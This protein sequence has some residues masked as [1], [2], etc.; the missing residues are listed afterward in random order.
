MLLPKIVKFVVQ[1]VVRYYLVVLLLAGL[2]TAVCFPR[3][4]KFFANINTD[5]TKLIPEHYKSVE[6]ITE[7]REKFKSI[8]TAILV[9]EDENPQ[10]AQDL[11]ANLATFLEKD[12]IIDEVE[13]KKRGYQFFE[14]HVLLFLELEDLETIRDRIDRRIQQEKLGSLYIDFEDNGEDE[15][16][17]FGDIE[18]KYKSKYSSGSTSPYYANDQETVYAMYIYPLKDPEEITDSKKFYENLQQKVAQFFKENKYPSSKIYFT[19]TIRTHVDEYDTLIHDLKKAGLISGLGIFL[20]LSLY[21]RRVITVGLLFLPISMAILITFAFSSLFIENL[22]LVTSFLFAILGGLGVEIGIHF[23]SRY[24]EERRIGK[25]I[26]QA[27]FAVLYHTGGSALTSA[28]SVAATFLILMVND[29]KGFSEFG[30]IAG[31]G[32]IMNYLCYVLVFPSLLV[33]AEKLHLLRFKRSIGL[34]FDQTQITS[35][36][37]LEHPKRFPVPKFVLV[38]LSVFAIISIIDLP[39]LEFE[40][41]FS[42]I[43]SNIPASLEAREK[44]RLTS[45]SVNSPAIVI[46]KNKEQAQAIKQAVKKLQENPGSSVNDFKSYYDLMPD[47]QMAKLE[48]IGQMH[49]LLEDDTLKLVKG[50]HKEDIERFKDVL[51]K[52][53]PINEEDIPPK[54]KEIFQGNVKGDTA[55]IGYINPLPLLEMD[56]GRNAIRFAKEIQQI[57]TPQGTFYPSNNAIVFA[58]VLRTMMKDSKRVIIMAFGIV[59]LI[60]LLDFRSVKATCLVLSPIV[61]GVL[62]LSGFMYILKLKLNFYN[63]IAAPIVVGTS[64]DNSV[65]LYH[66]Y[67]E[68]GKGSLIYALRSTGG[69]AFMS[70]MT[71]ICGFLGLVFA[72]HNGLQSIGDLAVTGMVACLITT[73]VFFPALLQVIEDRKVKKI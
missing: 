47:D 4:S 15:E 50:E 11:M 3:A 46:L 56:D 69:A 19:G 65:H 38:C 59:F 72:F 16:F 55:Q 41:R 51:A 34:E 58:D 13:Y 7:I 9:V 39:S 66:R 8:K 5:L 61:L 6:S 48:V 73:L 24:I 22:N 43:K 64:I 57:E 31:F 53:N 40:W 60:V 2:L 18:S 54:I 33:L 12:P 42:K 14:D 62:F 26:N 29:F 44:Q 67:K 37:I 20:I 49:K 30:F 52:M 71:N 70:S 23:L 32:L 10:V 17:K 28:V 1:K 27:L 35:Q 25:D 63:M 36:Y 21:F 68:M 45:K